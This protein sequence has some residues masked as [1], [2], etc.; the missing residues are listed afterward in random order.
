MKLGFRDKDELCKE[1][2]DFIE[3]DLI[4]ATKKS[5]ASNSPKKPQD[6]NNNFT[7]V[8]NKFERQK[9]TGPSPYFGGSFSN[10]R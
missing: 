8:H 3:S 4:P 9:T 10:S 2:K 5:G 7:S 6:S 1:L